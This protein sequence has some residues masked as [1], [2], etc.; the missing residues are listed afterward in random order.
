MLH[1]KLTHNHTEGCMV[2]K[3][4]QGQKGFMLE[5]HPIHSGAAEGFFC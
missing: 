3:N 1:Y 2:K 4:P 5:C